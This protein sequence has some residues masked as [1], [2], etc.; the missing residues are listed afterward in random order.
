MGRGDAVLV[1]RSL[2]APDLIARLAAASA[3]GSFT[4][5]GWDGAIYRIEIERIFAS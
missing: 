5:A 1:A 2:E 4:P 3:S